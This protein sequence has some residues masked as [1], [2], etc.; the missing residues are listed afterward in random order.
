M[1]HLYVMTRGIMHEVERTMTELASQY[2]HYEHEGKKCLLQVSVRPIQLWE[3]VVPEPMLPVI[4]NT[5]WGQQNYKKN[6]WDELSFKFKP[7]LWSIR[8]AL[9]ADKLPDLNK[10]AGS[11]M[12]HNQNVAIYPIGIKKNIMD[13]KIIFT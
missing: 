11:I 12:I 10:D 4:Q 6:V 2:L 9:G 1:V 7:P 8:T 13:E 3:I 5:L